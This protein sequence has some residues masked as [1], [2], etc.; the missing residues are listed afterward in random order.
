MKFNIFAIKRDLFRLIL[1]FSLFAFAIYILDKFDGD[2][3]ADIVRSCNK[4]DMKG[5]YTPI[6]CNHVVFFELNTYP[7]EE[8][9]LGFGAADYS[10]ESQYDFYNY[11]EK[12]DSLYRDID[13][14][15][16][17]KPNGSI[18]KWLAGCAEGEINLNEI[19]PGF[20]VP[21]AVQWRKARKKQGLWRQ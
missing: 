3:G 6:Y 5:I 2:I 15:Y 21:N 17:Y 13:T 19:R 14:I 10:S 11:A 18:T 8:F 16:L 20:G 4:K 9:K 7:N 12:G 1:F